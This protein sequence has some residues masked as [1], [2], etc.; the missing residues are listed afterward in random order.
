MDV[1]V[2]E[3]LHSTTL[4]PYSFQVFVSAAWSLQ[5]APTMPTGR[6]KSIKAGKTSLKRPLLKHLKESKG[7]GT[8]RNWTSMMETSESEDDIDSVEINGR[9]LRSRSRR[10]V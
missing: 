8:K 5:K 10:I 6:R 9:K 3:N 7:S 2:A 1:C 4:G